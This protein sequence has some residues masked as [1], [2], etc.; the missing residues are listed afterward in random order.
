MGGGDND[1]LSE[2]TATPISRKTDMKWRLQL[3]LPHLS[4]RSG[5][6]APSRPGLSGALW[7]HPIAAHPQ[8]PAPNT[9]ALPSARHG[10]R[11]FLASGPLHMRCPLPGLF[12]PNCLRDTKFSE[13]FLGV[14]IPPSKSGPT[15]LPLSQT[16]SEFTAVCGCVSAALTVSSMKAGINQSAC[17]P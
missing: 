17:S 4:G 8:A 7:G 16:F 12:F 2:G 10:T 6:S 1:L 15:V 5:R 13:A 11:L 9:L 3:K 14:S